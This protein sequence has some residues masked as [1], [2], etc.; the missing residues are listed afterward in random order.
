MAHRSSKHRSASEC[1]KHTVEK[2]AG[3]LHVLVTSASFSYFTFLL[4]LSLNFRKIVY[5]QFPKI[6]L[7]PNEYRSNILDMIHSM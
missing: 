1:D 6:P 5:F 4:S 3:K 2:C 7:F